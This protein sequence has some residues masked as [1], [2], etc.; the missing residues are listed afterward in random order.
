[1]A[2]IQFVIVLVSGDIMA[3]SFVLFNRFDVFI[4]IAAFLSVVGLTVSVIA[5]ADGSNDKNHNRLL[6]IV[7]LCSSAV[8][9]L[10]L[11]TIYACARSYESNLWDIDNI[12]KEIT[13]NLR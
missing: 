7:G 1:M 2:A 6:G 3:G 5:M 10:F 4:L 13:D 8:A 9:L 11:V 12:L